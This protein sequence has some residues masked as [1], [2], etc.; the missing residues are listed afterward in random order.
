MVG[1]VS[2]NVN[3]LVDVSSVYETAKLES[4]PDKSRTFVNHVLTPEQQ[5]STEK[6]LKRFS[7]IILPA[8]TNIAFGESVEFGEFDIE[9]LPDG[10]KA[11][12]SKKL[13]AFP[14]RNELKLTLRKTVD[15][16][17]RYL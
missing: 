12:K 10:V 5:A 4:G 17:V 15:E 2:L 7:S 9:L 3:L 14:V 1:A 6:L 11:L 8:G 16:L 13:R